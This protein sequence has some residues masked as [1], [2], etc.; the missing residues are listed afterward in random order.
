MSQLI[1]ENNGTIA[2]C[3]TDNDIGDEG[4]TLLSESLKVNTTLINFNLG[5]LELR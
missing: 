4:A 2:L 5:S 1:N 3:A